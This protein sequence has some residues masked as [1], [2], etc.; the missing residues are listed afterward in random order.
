M[1]MSVHFLVTG[2]VEDGVGHGLANDN[3]RLDAHRFGSQAFRHPVEIGLGFGSS[4]LKPR[5]F[6]RI[7]VPLERERHREIN[8]AGRLE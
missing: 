8:W 4:F 1:A 5:L 7:W 2:Y 6:D 3:V